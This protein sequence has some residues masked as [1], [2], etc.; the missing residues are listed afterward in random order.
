M[1]SAKGICGSWALDSQ[2]HEILGSVVAGS[3][4]LGEIFI[5]PMKD[6]LKSVR[7]EHRASEVRFPSKTDS[8][9]LS[10][11]YENT[12]AVARVLETFDNFPSDI[13]E[14]PIQDPIFNRIHQDGATMLHWSAWKGYRTI[15]EMLCA[16]GGDINARTKSMK[17]PLH[18]ACFLS[19]E[20]ECSPELKRRKEITV[21]FLLLQEG[22]DVNAT[23]KDD[24]T[25]LMIAEETGFEYAK[26]LFEN[27][28]KSWF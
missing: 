26:E 11:Y 15:L 12:E 27:Q 21:E 1:W 17:T 7:E 28:S 23:D 6:I 3:E 9:W 20:E 25:P 8:L 13:P 10:V 18:L 19:P 5:V 2:T 4:T 22:V 24:K 14:A 16:A